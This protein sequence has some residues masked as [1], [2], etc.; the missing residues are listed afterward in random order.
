MGMK[1]LLRVVFLAFAVCRFQMFL[2]PV[3]IMGKCIADRGN[4]E[5]VLKKPKQPITKPNPQISQYWEAFGLFK[6]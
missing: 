3:S 1:C 6:K 4:F 5:L 2:L